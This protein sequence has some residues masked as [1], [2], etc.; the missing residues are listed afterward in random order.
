[1]HPLA[2]LVSLSPRTFPVHFLNG[3]VVCC[4]C[5]FLPKQKSVEIVSSQE[6]R[7]L[8]DDPARL[9]CQ[10]F[11]GKNEQICL[12]GQDGFDCHVNR[13]SLFLYFVQDHN[14]RLILKFYYE[15]EFAG[16]ISQT[17]QICF[18]KIFV[19]SMPSLFCVKNKSCPS[20]SF[21]SELNVHTLFY[22]DFRQLRSRASTNVCGFLASVYVPYST[23]NVIH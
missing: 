15:V 4:T 11:L 12:K 17:L 20:F 19:T 21:D 7:I 9:D 8:V 23:W 13:K 22:F 5:T 10:N 6:Q 14:E 3:Q 16:D 2:K 1:M 18:P